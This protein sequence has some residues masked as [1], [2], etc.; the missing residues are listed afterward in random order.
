MIMKKFLVIFITMTCIPYVTTLAWSG[1]I[2]DGNIFG[3]DFSD[4]DMEAEDGERSVIVVRNGTENRI[5][6]EDFLIYVLAA[7]IPADFGMETLKA[8]AVLARTYIYSEM[9]AAGGDSAMEIYEEALDMDALSREQ[10]E[11]KWGND[12]FAK[13]Y[14]RL[15]DA[16]EATE[17]MCL[18]YGKSYAEPLFCYASAGTTRSG[19]DRYPYLKQAE[20]K[21]DLL[22]D[23]YLS[24]AVFS[25]EDMAEQI[26]AIPDAVSVRAG[27]L[28][29]EIQIVERDSAG[30]VKQVK[31]GAKTYT[32][33]EVQYA[34][35][36]SSPCFSFDELDGNIR[37]T[38]KGV[39]HGYGFSQFG[40]N[41]LEKSG[42][43]FQELLAWFF[44]DVEIH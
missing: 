21:A 9:E 32:G 30:Y 10:M 5:S 40:A 12:E 31:I 42:M 8:Q 14:K 1:R 23:G 27:E 7:Q 43:D 34:L 33:E 41:E 2:A 29:A 37:V 36:L 6:V 18:W 16:A 26:S 3:I 44:K 22:A 4:K 11:K 28:P 39:G 15:T 38:C 17:G 25:A 24:F 13:M 19:G 20:S 35:G